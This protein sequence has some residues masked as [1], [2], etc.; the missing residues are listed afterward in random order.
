[1]KTL[2]LSSFRAEHSGVEETL[3][4]MCLNGIERCLAFGQH[5][6]KAFELPQ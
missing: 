6:E 3:D 1:M 5:D 2:F 4:Q